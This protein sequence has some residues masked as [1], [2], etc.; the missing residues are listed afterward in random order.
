M[1]LI[2]VWLAQLAYH[3][4][5]MIGAGYLEGGALSASFGLFA[6]ADLPVTLLFAWLAYRAASLWPAV[7]FHSFHNTISQWLFPRFFNN[8]ADGPWLGEDGVLPVAGYVVVGT[9]VFLWLHW[10]GTSWQTLSRKALQ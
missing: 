5:L 1:S 4:P 2:V 9:T 7:L 8:S 6:A 3:L 10:R